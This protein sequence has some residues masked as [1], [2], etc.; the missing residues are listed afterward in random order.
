MGG[1]PTGRYPPSSSW[2]TI[3]EAALPSNRPRICGIRRGITAPMWPAPEAT[4]LRTIPR[5][6]SSKSSVG[7]Y[8]RSTFAL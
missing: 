6:S 5:T 8:P 2:R 7:R 4:M 3:A 1:L